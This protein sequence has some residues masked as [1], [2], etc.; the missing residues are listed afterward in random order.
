MFSI[1]SLLNWFYPHEKWP[2]TDRNIGFDLGEYNQI[3]SRLYVDIDDCIGCLQ[4]ERACPV[5][6][7][8][9][10]TVKPPKGNDYDCGLTSNN[11]QK[12]M[13]VPRFTIDMSECMYCNLCV[14]PCPE[15]CIYMVGGPNEEKHNMDYEF[16]KYT[17]DGLIFEFAETTDQDLLDIGAETY[18]EKRNEVVN[19]RD[20][21]TRLEGLVAE[22]EKAKVEAEKAKD[23][24]DSTQAEDEAEP[25][26]SLSIFNEVEDKM[27]RGI[28]KKAFVSA[29][30]NKMDQ[31]GIAK[32]VESAVDSYGKLGD[33]IKQAISSIRSFVPDSEPEKSTNQKDPEDQASPSKDSTDEAPVATE[34]LFSIKELDVIEDK[35]VRGI[36]KKAYMK[37]KR[38]KLFSDSAV[39]MILK[40]LEENEK[41]NDDIKQ[42]VEKLN[43]SNNSSPSAQSAEK[44]SSP[45]D[46]LKEEPV[47]I[48]EL[49]SIKKLDVLDDKVVRGV[50]KKAYMKAKREKSY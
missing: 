23:K 1:F 49:F 48:K 16:S 28:A 9:I 40:S 10:D 25:G 45:K 12:K 41:I 38:E 30:R 20:E 6:C 35:V 5:D 34:T 47:S 13:L 7:I 18:L 39:A 42:A 4:C 11:T 33:D 19:K 32:S 8:K 31:E 37:A 24:T 26:L 29:E 21:G 50:A 3:R 46:P 2:I 17:K 43:I 15:E 36:A 44:S 14:H 27:T 22:L